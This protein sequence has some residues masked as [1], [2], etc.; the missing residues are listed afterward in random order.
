MTAL[1]LAIIFTVACISDLRTRRIP[2]LLVVVAAVAGTIVALLTKSWSAGLI[3]AGAGLGTGL[4][5]WLPFYA[6]G[7][8]GAGDV[9]LFAA[10]STFLGPRSAVEASLYTAF[11]GGVLA[12]GYMLGR[13]GVAS[14]LIRV[15]Q[16]VRQPELLRNDP[17]AQRRRMPY[18][19][20]IAAGVLTVVFW[21]GYIVT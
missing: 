16:G 15:S 21:P 2:N 8:L 7:M 10:A 17:T 5:I 1:C 18:A 4:A 11:Y 19:L 20:A 13:S 12:L 3:Q 14:T 6:L 9:K